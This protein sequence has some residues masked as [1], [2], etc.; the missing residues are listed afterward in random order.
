[1]AHPLTQYRLDRDLTQQA[2][3][4]NFETTRATINRWENGTRKIT[5]EK[6]IEIE[7]KTN[8]R[9]KRAELRPDL[10]SKGREKPKEK[11]RS[12]A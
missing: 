8:G 1:M 12:T 9:I 5:A 4:I 11:Q 10:F 6:A 7:A 2:L 3:A